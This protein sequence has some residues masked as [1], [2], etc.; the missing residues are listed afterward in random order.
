[1]EIDPDALRAD[2]RRFF[3]F[4]VRPPVPV[5]GLGEA[6]PFVEEGLRVLEESGRVRLVPSGGEVVVRSGGAATRSRTGAAAILVLPPMDATL[7][8]GVNRFLEE[9]G[10]DWR[11]GAPLD[12]GSVPLGPSGPPGLEG[13]EVMGGYRL[14]P[15]DAAAPGVLATT[16]NGEPWLVEAV[17]SGTR[18]LILSSPL[19]PGFT[20][21]PVRAGMIPFLDWAVTRWAA[22]SSPMDDVP[23]GDELP[24]PQGATAVLTPD[25][26]RL[27]LGR[28]GVV[29]RRARP[30]PGIYRFLAGDSV[31]SVVAVNVPAR[32]SDLTRSGPD[33]VAGLAG[34]EGTVVASLE[35]WGREVFRT[36]TGPEGGGLLLI[37]ALA[38]LLAEGF[39]AASG[40]IRSGAPAQSP[41]VGRAGGGARP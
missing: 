29:D 15:S 21:L 37:L 8:P 1:V 25:E 27:E 17:G 6:G 33:L 18:A 16:R 20:T 7:L 11:Y 10:V 23:A 31:L 14:I 3:A 28:A 32:E 38:L 41:P 30:E 40:Q 9:I 24:T 26:V 39:V 2:D 4:R 35:G 5:S 19:A 22:G 36:R 34:E 13:V 12:P